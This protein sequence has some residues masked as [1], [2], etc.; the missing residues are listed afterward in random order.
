MANY[1]CRNGHTWEGKSSLSRGFHPSETRC[2]E[3]GA[4]ADPK[5]KARSKSEP[6]VVDERYPGHQSMY[7]RLK[8]ESPA[9]EAVAR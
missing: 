7:E 6:P 4:Q 2:R 1:A 3:C 8:L 9:R 5:M